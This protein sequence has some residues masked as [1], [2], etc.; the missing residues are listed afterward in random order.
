MGVNRPDNSQL[1]IKLGCGIPAGQHNNTRAGSFFRFTLVG[2]GRQF[3]S[4][5]HYVD[6]VGF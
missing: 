5:D 4:F 6:H 1:I 2:S 3:I